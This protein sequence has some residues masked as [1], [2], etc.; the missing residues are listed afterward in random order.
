MLE[1]MFATV[2]TR[3]I[4]KESGN[5]ASVG[6]FDVVVIV[7]GPTGP[8]V[9]YHTQDRA[10]L[11]EK[12]SRVGGNCRW[13]VETGFTCLPPGGYFNRTFS[14]LFLRVGF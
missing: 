13:L 6:S 7:A 3:K 10:V 5:G 12:N 1:L 11:L 2:Q 14:R 9:T 4:N 8:S